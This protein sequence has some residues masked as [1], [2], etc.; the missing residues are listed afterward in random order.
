MAPPR[1]A[2][3]IR[4]ERPTS[5]AAQAFDQFHGG[6]GGAAGGDEVVDDGDAVA[7]ANGV[8]VDLD[9]VDAVLELVGGGGG[10]GGQLVGFAQGDEAAAEFAGHGGGED[11]AAGLDGGDGQ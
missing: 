5:F 11:E 6:D 2:R 4:N 8:G 1:N 3:S 7:G 9:G 10:G